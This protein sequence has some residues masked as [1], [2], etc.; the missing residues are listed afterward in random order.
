MTAAIQKSSSSTARGPDGLCSLHLKYLGPA[1]I[2]YLTDVFNLSIK[3][4]VIPAVWKAALD[5]PVLKPEKPADQGA[6]YRPISL[7]SPVVKILERLMLSALNNAFPL[8]SSHH[9]F[10]PDHSMIIALLPIVSQ[11]SEG[12]NQPEPASRTVVVA[13]NLSKAFDTV[14]ITLLIEKI[15]NLNLN[16]NYVRWLSIYLRWQP[17]FTKGLAQSLG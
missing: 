16:H 1:G 4:N 7:V 14:A 5:V 9:G 11:I 8:R 13:I 15:S 10:T 12:F 2:V 3:D 17:A 6:S